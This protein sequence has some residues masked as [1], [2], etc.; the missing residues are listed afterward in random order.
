MAR[1]RP[2]LSDFGRITARAGL[3]FEFEHA[4]HGREPLGVADRVVVCFE[5]ADEVGGVGDSRAEAFADGFPIGAAAKV[6]VAAGSGRR[7]ND[8]ELADVG[9]EWDPRLLFGVELVDA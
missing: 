6:V 5:H 7:G 8:V 1:L 2:F 4:A 3:V 9:D